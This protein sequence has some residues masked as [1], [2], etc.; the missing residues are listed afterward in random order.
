MNNRLKWKRAALLLAAGADP[1]IADAQGIT[2]LQHARSRRQTEIADRL[3]AAG[4]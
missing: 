4:G 3:A 1:R 2:P